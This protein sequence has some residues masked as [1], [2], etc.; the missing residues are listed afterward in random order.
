VVGDGV[1]VAAT[2]ATRTTP[3]GAHGVALPASPPAR[4]AARDAKAHATASPRRR[5]V[6]FVPRARKVRR[7]GG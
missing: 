2:A 7:I 3:E 6:R 1:A 5:P 4:A